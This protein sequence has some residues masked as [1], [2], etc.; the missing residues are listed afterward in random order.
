MW[1]MINKHSSFE[2]FEV[3]FIN[4]LSS[5]ILCVHYIFESLCVDY[6]GALVLLSG[7]VIEGA[8]PP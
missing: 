5:N 4:L 6:K 2:F 8:H 3:N 1:Q 7:G